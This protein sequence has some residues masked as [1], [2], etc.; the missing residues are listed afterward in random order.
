MLTTWQKREGSE[1]TAAFRSFLNG[2]W[3]DEMA[4][5]ADYTSRVSQRL[6]LLGFME[7]SRVYFFVYFVTILQFLGSRASFSLHVVHT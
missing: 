3:K 6:F 4:N 1:E 2:A 7:H 5:S